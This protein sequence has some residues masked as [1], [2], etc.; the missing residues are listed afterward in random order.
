MARCFAEDVPRW[1]AGECFVK[2]HELLA[3]RKVVLL[4][5]VNQTSDSKRNCKQQGDKALQ[6]TKIRKSK[7]TCKRD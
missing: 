5:P 4:G 3:V 7:Q 6:R 2:I 1:F